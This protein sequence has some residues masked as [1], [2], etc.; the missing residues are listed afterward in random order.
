MIFLNKK[1]IIIMCISLLLIISTGVYI[2]TRADSID[3]ANVQKQE[4]VNK[5]KNNELTNKETDAKLIFFRAY[6]YKQIY[7]PGENLINGIYGNRSLYI[8]KIDDMPEINSIKYKNKDK[9][10]SFNNYLYIKNKD[11]YLVSVCDNI[12]DPKN[13]EIQLELDTNAGKITKILGT[14]SLEEDVTKILSS[15]PKITFNDSINESGFLEIAKEY[16]IVNV[17]EETSLLK[18]E[19]FIVSRDDLE[20]IGFPYEENI[21]VSELGGGSKTDKKGVKILKYTLKLFTKDIDKQTMS[22]IEEIVSKN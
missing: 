4:D 3:K 18:E 17:G 1:Q 6:P 9:T 5:V 11:T 10:L 8:I 16:S 19:D 14:D 22:Q 12:M 20:S 2:F 13:M 7:L 21:E 15:S